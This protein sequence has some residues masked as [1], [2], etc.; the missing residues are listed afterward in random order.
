MRETEVKGHVP[1]GGLKALCS[2]PGVNVSFVR[3]LTE[4]KQDLRI[5]AWFDFDNPLHTPEGDAF[6]AKLNDILAPPGGPVIHDRVCDSEGRLTGERRLVSIIRSTFKISKAEQ[7]AMWEREVKVCE[8]MVT[9]AKSP[10]QNAREYADLIDAWEWFIEVTDA[11]RAVVG[12][13]PA[14][15][16]E[17]SDLLEQ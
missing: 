1:E 2:I 12:L 8:A 10:S 6:N 3:G 4:E 14:I 5:I 17:E 11:L 9:G 15:D 7:D 13:P 16:E